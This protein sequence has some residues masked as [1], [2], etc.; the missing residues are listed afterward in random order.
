[1]P[2]FGGGEPRCDLGRHSGTSKNSSRGAP[3]GTPVLFALN[4][5]RFVVKV[6][7]G[8]DRAPG[9]ARGEA[10]L[11]GEREKKS[12][13]GGE[14]KTVVCDRWLIATAQKKNKG[15]LSLRKNRA[16]RAV[17]IPSSGDGNRATQKVGRKRGR[18]FFFFFS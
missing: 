16:D 2:P 8:G 18:L 1:M 15:R 4:G 17:R 12:R 10:G 9:S 7:P 11:R 13:H 3:A 6:V 14:W 5:L